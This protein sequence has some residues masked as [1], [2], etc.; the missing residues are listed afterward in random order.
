MFQFEELPKDCMIGK[1][2][3]LEK[4][5]D[6]LLSCNIRDANTSLRRAR[7]HTM[8]TGN[9]CN[10]HCGGESYLEIGPMVS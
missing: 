3:P 10:L 5:V 1:R 2:H 8:R 7:R 6:D 4:D 9:M